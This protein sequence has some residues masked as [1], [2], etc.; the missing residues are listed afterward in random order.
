MG[1]HLYRK[2]TAVIIILA[3]LAMNVPASFAVSASS[4]DKAYLGSEKTVSDLGALSGWDEESVWIVLGLSRAGHLKK[5]DGLKYKNNIL[6]KVRK[7]GSPI[8]NERQSSDNA[9]A[10]IA[11]TACGYDPTDLGGYNLTEPLA[12]MGFVMKQGINGPVW[13][14]IALDTYDY[15]IPDMGIEKKQVTREKLT[16]AI[17]SSQKKDGGWA[18]SGKTSDVDMTC[19]VL[20]ALAPYYKSDEKCR[21]AVDTA[22]EWLSS[23]Q[24]S[25]GAFTS[26]GNETSESSS[27]VIVALT[28][29][30][31]DPVKDSR[32]L[33]NRKGALDS[34]LSFY[35]NEGG[36]KHVSS[37]YKVNNMATIQGFYALV[38]YY[39]MK[40]GKNS[41]YEMSDRDSG[42]KISVR[43]GG[44]DDG[45]APED[46]KPEKTDTDEGKDPGNKNDKTEHEKNKGTS[47]KKSPAVSEKSSHDNSSS[48]L[49]GLT[50]V[51]KKIKDDS[52]DPSEDK[53][54]KNDK[55]K[56]KTKLTGSANDA[57][58]N[59]AEDEPLVDDGSGVEKGNVSPWLYVIIA[60]VIALAAV[61]VIRIRAGKGN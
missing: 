24:K 19:M 18:F 31:K 27:Q 60:A 26:G 49:S 32:F 12:D 9:R 46:K 30:G 10:V 23:V 28:A 7:N 13:T 20:Q 5:G 58:N 44:E 25:N 48:D 17:I 45:K 2:L 55:E 47:E 22:L 38:A 35:M 33:K 15:G 52:D 51:T 37:N 29:L 57:Q 43:S 34:L 36:F 6:A 11:L 50:G 14:L 59:S 1:I 4:F 40:D 56:D 61:T 16:A 21:N 8:I 39:R 54:D 41:L 42:Y 53:K 3:M